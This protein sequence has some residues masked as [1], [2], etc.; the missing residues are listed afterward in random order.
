MGNDKAI[1]TI[2]RNAYIPAYTL[3]LGWL[4]IC[5]IGALYHEIQTLKQGADHQH[6]IA[7]A[8]QGV[9]LRQQLAITNGYRSRRTMSSTY[10]IDRVCSK[11]LDHLRPSLPRLSAVYA[12]K[13]K[14][15]ILTMTA[16]VTTSNIHPKI[17]PVLEG[18]DYTLA[19]QTRMMKRTHR[20]QDTAHLPLP[21][22]TNSE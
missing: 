10:L 17:Y 4:Y 3:H 7:R 9:H 8:V 20:F 21:S 13:T 5:R 18:R 1:T 22:T 16:T 6:V 15:T 2:S 19:Y 12:G 11:E 14:K